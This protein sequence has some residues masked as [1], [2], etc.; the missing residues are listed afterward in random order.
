MVQRGRKPQ[1][2]QGYWPPRPSSALLVLSPPETYPP[3]FLLLLYGAK[4]NGDFSVIFLLVI[5]IALDIEAHP[6]YEMLSSFPLA[7][8]KSP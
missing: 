7:L 3:N 4:P 8:V 5:S 1:S 6:S 2:T